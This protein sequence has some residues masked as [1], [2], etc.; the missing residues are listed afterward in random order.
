[1]VHIM[2]PDNVG[3]YLA[4]LIHDWLHDRKGLV[5]IEIGCYAG[6]STQV[7]ADSGVFGR[8]YCIDPWQMGYDPDDAAGDE[9]IVEA[10]QLFDSRFKDSDIITK[11]KLKS[12]DAVSMF[13]DCSIDFIYID[14][15]HQYQA[16]KQDLTDYVPKVKSGGVIAGHD[17]MYKATPGVAKAVDE[18]FGVQPLRRYLDCSWVYIKQ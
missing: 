1:M 6:E 13:E 8:L 10:E 2:R 12:H 11:V 7:F 15:N 18:F 3:R 16:V 17:Y 14:G 4:E 5:G 9:H